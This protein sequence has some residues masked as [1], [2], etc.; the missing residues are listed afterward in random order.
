MTK[1]AHHWSQCFPVIADAETGAVDHADDNNR[2]IRKIFKGLNQLDR[3]KFHQASC[4]NRWSPAHLATI[5]KIRKKLHEAGIGDPEMIGEDLIPMV[6]IWPTKMAQN[7]PFSTPNPV[8]IDHTLTT[9]DRCGVE[10]WIGPHQLALHR[11]AG[12]ERVC[13]YCIN[14]DPEL[15]TGNVATAT[16]NPN[17]DDRPRRF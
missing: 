8:S 17:A 15:A 14:K 11:D 3:I 6:I 13:A 5:N 9:C 7:W 12:A 4:Q 10:A 2:A 1:P 16:L